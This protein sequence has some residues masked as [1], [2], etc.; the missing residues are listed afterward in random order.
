MAVA[1]IFLSYR[2]ADGRYAVGWLAERLSQLDGVTGVSGVNT[3]F[4]DGELRCGDDFPSALENEI[5]SCDV[6]V[7]I[8]GPNWLGRREDGTNRIQDETD[9]VGREIRMALDADKMVM[10]VLVGGVDPLVASDLSESLQPLV[11]RHSVPFE[12]AHDLANVAKDLQGH[13]ERIDNERARTAG[14]DDELPLPPLR[15]GPL[16]FAL[17]LA[18]A[19]VGAFIGWTITNIELGDSRE[20]QKVADHNEA[21]TVAAMIQIGAWAGLCVLGVHYFWHHFRKDVTIK[22]RPVLITFAFGALLLA[23]V[24]LVF[25]ASAPIRF[26]AER[27]WLLVVLP[28]VLLAPWV[29]TATG[30]AWTELRDETDDDRKRPIGLG[31]RSIV[32]GEMGRASLLSTAVLVV[33]G[34]PGVLGAGGVARTLKACRC[35]TT[36]Q[37]QMLIAFG[38]LISAVFAGIALWSR[39]RLRQASIAL[40]A[41]L[42]DLSP[43]HQRN[44]RQHTID[45]AALGP[46]WLSVG[47]ALPLLTGIAVAFWV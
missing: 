26:D 4:R 43:R 34:V 13:L 2:R 38:L 20:A 31:R 35:G 47:L 29:I 30:T 36:Y 37:P 22:W 40:E 42:I 44:A 12:N 45:E 23:W 18:A 41:E 8:I 28:I 11:A 33:A 15:F 46:W 24:I 7:A 27:S 39:A 19:A 10:P 6:L 3:V 17:T 5:R 21:W 9:W 16:T 14:L 1:R 25:G 32:L